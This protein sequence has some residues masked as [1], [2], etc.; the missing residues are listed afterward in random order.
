MDPGQRAPALANEPAER[1]DGGPVLALMDQAVRGI[2]PPAVGTFEERDKR[3]RARGAQLRRT[4]RLG[5][6]RCNPVDAALVAAPP[7]VEVL[8]DVERDVDR[9]DDLTAHV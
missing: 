9:L 8:H 1:F 7:E 3:G 5:A 4:G 6:R 2:A